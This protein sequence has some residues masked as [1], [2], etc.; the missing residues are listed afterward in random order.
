MRKQMSAATII[1]GILV[2][3]KTSIFRHSFSQVKYFY[4][5]SRYKT[6]VAQTRFCNFIKGMIAA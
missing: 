5:M 3:L 1:T 2:K 6:V 4:Q